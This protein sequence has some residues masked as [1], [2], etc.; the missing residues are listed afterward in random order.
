MPDVVDEAV[1]ELVRAPEAAAA[2]RAENASSS[3]LSF[4]AIAGSTIYESGGHWR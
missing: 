1:R 2:S 3:S 4:S